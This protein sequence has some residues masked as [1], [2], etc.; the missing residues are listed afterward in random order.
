MPHFLSKSYCEKVVSVSMC[1]KVICAGCN[2]SLKCVQQNVDGTMIKQQPFRDTFEDM[3]QCTV[4]S[5]YCFII[6]LFVGAEKRNSW[7][8]DNHTHEYL[9]HL[10]RYFL[11]KI[12][13]IKRATLI[14]NHHFLLP[15]ATL[16]DISPAYSSW[17]FLVASIDSELWRWPWTLKCIS[18]SS[19]KKGWAH[20]KN[21][22]KCSDLILLLFKQ[23]LLNRFSAKLSV[24][25]LAIS[26]ESLDCC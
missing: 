17:G 15:I 5:L 19:C 26:K 24:R 14:Y 22:T 13:E 8:S 9:I 23:R 21:L 25:L 16:A 3:G 11:D 18:C 7:V 6:S 1:Q 20:L 4:S 12:S 2:I 10:I